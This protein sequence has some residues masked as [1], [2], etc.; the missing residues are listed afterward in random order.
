MVMCML[1]HCLELELIP[2]QT[3]VEYTYYTVAAVRSVAYTVL[4]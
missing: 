4:V 3:V 2:L 1:N